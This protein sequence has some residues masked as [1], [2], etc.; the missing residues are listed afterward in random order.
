MS[1]SAHAPE[2]KRLDRW[3]RLRTSAEPRPQMSHI[4]FVM[5]GV[6]PRASGKPHH[7]QAFDSDPGFLRD[8]LRPHVA[9]VN[10]NH[11]VVQAPLGERSGHDV[12]FP[13]APLGPRTRRSGKGRGGSLAQERPG[14]TSGFGARFLDAAKR[15]TLQLAPWFS[16]DPSS[17]AE[18]SWT[19]HVEKPAGSS[20]TRHLFSITP[21]GSCRAGDAPGPPGRQTN[22]WPLHRDKFVL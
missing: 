2:P 12:S 6:P 10:N 13:A 20:S 4:T 11:E 8:L 19:V 3:A 21:L 22:L 18:A 5:L 14:S 16:D 9:P 7:N 17:T 15:R 1:S